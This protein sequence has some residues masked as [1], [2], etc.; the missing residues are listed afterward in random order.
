MAEE[1]P[2]LHHLYWL[3]NNLASGVD[4]DALRR[5]LGELRAEPIE[6]LARLRMPVLCLAGEEDIVIP[7]ETVRILATCLPDGR[8]VSIPQAGHSVYFERAE[9]FNSIVGA[10]LDE[11]E[12]LGGQE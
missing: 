1:Q 3:I 4:K 10:F 8:F 9:K 11:V 2:A 12:T 6:S 7:P 5:Q